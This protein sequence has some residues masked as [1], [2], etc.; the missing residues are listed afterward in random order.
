MLGRAGILLLA[1]C[2]VGPVGC[3]APMAG[4]PA[5]T[6]SAGPAAPSAG[7]IVAIRE[8]PGGGVAV[9]A[10][11]RAAGIAAIAPRA[12]M[13]EYI[14]IVEGR[15]PVSVVQRGD[16]RLSVGDAVTLAGGPRTRLVRGGAPPPPGANAAA[17]RPA[18]HG[19][20]R[21]TTVASA[22]RMV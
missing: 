14:V 10:A 12:V 7:I 4:P 13:R 3:A 11:L 19:N 6:D 21:A 2:V 17:A 15:G 16:D 9:N 8:S 1:A 20:P 5:P 22:R 18:A